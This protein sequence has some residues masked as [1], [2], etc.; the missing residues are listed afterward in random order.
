MKNWL[1]W[2]R[3][4]KRDKE[5]LS[6]KKVLLGLVILALALLIYTYGIIPLGE[7]KK[8]ADEE[9]ASKQRVLEKYAEVLRSRKSVEESRDR[10][11]K[12]ND[13]IQKKLLPGETPQLGAVNLQDIV[14]RLSDKNNMTLRSF[15]ILE[16]KEASMYR[17]ISLQIELNPVNSM[18]N[19]SQFLYDLEH[20][21]KALMISDMDLLVFN[22][23]MPNNIQGTLVISGLMKGEKAREKGKEK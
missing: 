8:S 1:K 5:K 19:L 16:P 13:E 15:R 6:Q 14:K 22:P 10:V 20:Q 7:A 11:L 12:L 18:R 17:K 23:R 9:I 21:D 2:D 3:W 4:F